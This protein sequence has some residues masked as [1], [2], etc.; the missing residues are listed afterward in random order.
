MGQH[1]TEVPGK[2]TGVGPK[3]YTSAPCPYFPLLALVGPG[4]PFWVCT[5]PTVLPLSVTP[6]TS[7]P[8][9]QS[10]GG[11]VPPFL[12]PDCSHPS[13]AQR[14]GPCPPPYAPVEPA[15]P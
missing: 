15:L 11:R 5:V 14:S 6:T 13:D 7:I 8:L 10:E 2:E 1:S 4:V 3:G 12:P 9:S